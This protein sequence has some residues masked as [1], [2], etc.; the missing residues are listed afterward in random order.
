MTGRRDQDGGVGFSVPQE[1][2]DLAERVTRHLSSYSLD[3]AT[4]AR[5][6]HHLRE[7]A[8]AQP[9]PKSVDG[10]VGFQW[11]QRH[12]L[13]H[14]VAGTAAASLA[15]VMLSGS[16]VAAYAQTALP[17]DPLYDTK[18]F[19]EG[20]EERMAVTPEGKVAVRLDH[21]QKRLGEAETLVA[22][23]VTDERLVA[24]LTEHQQ[25]LREA[26]EIAANDE[27]LQQ[28]VAESATRASVQLL[29]IASAPLPEPASQ[30]AL[31][32]FMTAQEVASPS[33]STP[34]VFVQPDGTPIAP[35]ESPAPSETEPEIL[36]AP[37]PSDTPTPPPVTDTPTPPAPSD[38]PSP[39]ETET[40]PP[41]P[42][43]ETLP[44]PTGTGT[45]DDEKKGGNGTGGGQGDSQDP[46]ST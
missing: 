35:L 45:G 18:R 20:V 5:H 1:Y 19:V 14:R 3:P 21:A 7:L 17:G 26:N 42:E 27:G 11:F 46:S 29:P 24:T 16:A 15:A 43:T 28:Q 4:R 41:P 44:A 8:A 9:P 6:L 40:P 34:P 31:D 37:A 2:A 12:G 36:P 32:A 33:V 25:E 10:R 13:L 22:Q 30:S 39:S 38:T 23:G